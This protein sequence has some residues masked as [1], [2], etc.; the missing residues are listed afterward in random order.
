[1]D[2]NESVN[3]SMEALI[4]WS[5]PEIVKNKTYDGNCIN[6]P[7][8]ILE[9]QAANM[10][11]FDIV[12]KQTPLKEDPPCGNILSPMWDS[13]VSRRIQKSVSLTDI[14]GVAKLLEQNYIDHDK[15]DCVKNQSKDDCVTSKCV[16]TNVIEQSKKNVLVHLGENKIENQE[17]P[18][19]LV[20]GQNE[21]DI[22]KNSYCNEQEKKQIREQTRQRIEIL[23]EKGKKNYEECYSRKSLF[24][25]PKRSNTES[26]LNSSVLNRGF[27]GSFNINSNTVNKTPDSIIDI[28][29]NITPND[30]LAFPFHELNSFDLNSLKPEWVV[31]N[32]SDG[33]GSSEV[34]SK[35]N[36]VTEIRPPDNI[37]QVDVKLKTLN[38]LGIV[39]SK[40]N[41][42]QTVLKSMQNKRTHI[43]G[44]FIANVP[45][46][47]MVQNFKDVEMKDVSHGS[48]SPRKMKPIASST[49]TAS[50]I[51]TLTKTP[52]TAESS[53][54]SRSSLS[55]RSIP[56]SVSPGTPLNVTKC[57]QKNATNT[58]IVLFGK[59]NER[60]TEVLRS[61]K[62]NKS[63]SESKLG[64]IPKPNVLNTTKISG[65]PV[66]KRFTMSFKG[67]ENVKP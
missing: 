37:H 60:N 5:T 16:S 6:N 3:C 61:F 36:S 58:T 8:D 65:L 14:H 2:A 44:P 31:D 26:N 34:S 62:L 38:R 1:M 24:C 52:S 21:V 7:F 53:I 47:H 18:I 20:P 48:V 49:P 43:K 42:S 63:K 57:I 55:R 32:F 9:L 35:E 12:P 27:I 10:D 59:T 28:N 19:K 67:K 33:D 50:D 39:E 30:S 46:K 51:V 45:V 15:D 54:K 22:E 23:I 40:P 11:P 56:N 41:G 4:D 64:M 17:S 25:T 13:N 66:S 29:E